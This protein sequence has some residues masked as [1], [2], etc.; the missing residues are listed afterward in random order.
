MHF[1]YTLWLL[2]PSRI[3]FLR[4]LSST[5]PKLQALVTSLH[6]SMNCGSIRSPWACSLYSKAATILLLHGLHCDSSTS[7]TLSSFLLSSLFNPAFYLY[8]SS[9][10][11]Q[12]KLCTVNDE[13][14]AFFLE[15]HSVSLESCFIFLVLERSVHTTY[16]PQTGVAV[17]L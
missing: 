6:F 1:S 8:G 14:V 5:S 2:R 11:L 7:S 4:H 13:V 9:H 12:T 15:L 16:C 17:A 3:A 10:F